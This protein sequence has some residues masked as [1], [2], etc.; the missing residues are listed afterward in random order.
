LAPPLYCVFTT[1]SWPLV[2]VF[3]PLITRRSFHSRRG[4]IARRR[5][6]WSRSIR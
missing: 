4:A 5:R 6:S 2:V 3:I 1:P